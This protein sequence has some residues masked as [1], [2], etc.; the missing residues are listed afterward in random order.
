MVSN[1]ALPFILQISAF[2]SL[3]SALSFRLCTVRESGPFDYARRRLWGTRSS[4]P[5]VL[6]FILLELIPLVSRSFP[7]ED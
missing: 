5:F 7:S 3:L 2:T 4:F 1:A 6:A